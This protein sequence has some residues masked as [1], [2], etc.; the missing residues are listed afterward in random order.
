MIPV[1]T[2]GIGSG[3]VAGAGELGAF[4]EKATVLET[5]PPGDGFTTLMFRI[6]AEA[7]SAAGI[8]AFRVVEFTKVVAMVAV[9]TCTTEFCR[10]FE[11]VSV[12]ATLLLPCAAELGETADTVGTGLAEVG[13][14]TEKATVLDT[15]PPGDGFTTLMFRV[16]AEAKSAA[17]ITAVKVV[18]LTNVVAA[19]VVP[20]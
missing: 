11:P 5:P 10:K 12:T 19:G 18:E 3:V 20:I 1:S 17:G 15:P 13:G 14:F 16:P 2:S 4:T 7:R 9:P 6:P 8:T